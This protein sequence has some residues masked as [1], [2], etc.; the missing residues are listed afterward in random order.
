MFAQRQS[1]PASFSLVFFQLHC[2]FS[3]LPRLP[4]CQKFKSEIAKRIASNFAR[5]IVR[6]IRV[7]FT[8][9]ARR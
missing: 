3:N 2:R 7:C 9:M 6:H 8:K 5:L 4:E 1:S